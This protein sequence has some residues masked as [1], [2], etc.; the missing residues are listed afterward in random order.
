MN[1]HEWTGMNMKH[2][3]QVVVQ[4]FVNDFVTRV[5]WLHVSNLSPSAPVICR[6]PRGEPLDETDLK[7]VKNEDQ[8]I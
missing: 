8:K 4:K 5:Q 2:G 7:P 3:V 6:S 1:E